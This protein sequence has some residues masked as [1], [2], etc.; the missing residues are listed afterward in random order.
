MI[1][2][3]IERDGDS[4][5]YVQDGMTVQYAGE[6]DTILEVLDEEDAII[7]V[8]RNWV[9][10]LP[11]TDEEYLIETGQ[12]EAEEYLEE[13]QD[14]EGAGEVDFIASEPLLPVQANSHGGTYG[15]TDEESN[16]TS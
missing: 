8:F 7:A 1:K 5:F 14:D 9:Y 15:L 12:A 16:P 13:D 6:G 11:I 3:K 10:G 4:V 2:V